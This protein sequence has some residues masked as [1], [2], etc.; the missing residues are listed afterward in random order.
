MAVEHNATDQGAYMSIRCLLRRARGRVGRVVAV[1][2]LA[3]VALL[4]AGCGSN[5]DSSGVATAGGS[6][7]QASTT[8]AP[9]A[10]QEQQALRFTKCM[11]EQ[12]VNMADPTVDA[13][14]NVRLRPPM[15]SDEPSQAKLQKARDA[16]QQYLQGLQQD[17]MGQDQTKFRDSLLKYAR[18][19]RKN[20][21][22]LPDPN[23]SNQGASGGGPFGDAIDQNDPA[24]KKAD[25]VCRSNLPGLFGGGGGG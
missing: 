11:R 23:F 2:V 22:D 4:V 16:C 25:A 13:S 17:V 12:G 1:A 7:G 6:G 20:G 15:G 21:Y 8:T 24:F 10:N 19:M 5:S 18:C 3:V 14:G 9:K